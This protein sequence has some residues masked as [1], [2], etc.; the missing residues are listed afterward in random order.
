M[1]SQPRR[2]LGRQIVVQKYGG[3]SVA[4]TEKLRHVARRVA[5]T[6][7]LGLDIVV[8]VSA[9]GKTTDELLGLAHSLHR[10]PPRRELDVLVSSGERISMALLSMA[11]EEQ[12]WSAISLS[13]PQSGIRTDAN[14]FGARIQGVQPARVLRELA[15]GR[16]VVVAGYQ[17]ESPDGEITT[18]GRG[19]SDTSAVA[20]AAVLGAL[21]CEIYSDVPGVFTADPRIVDQAA[22]LERVSYEE[23]IA[24]SNLG[25]SVLDRRAVEHAARHRVEIHA[26]P[27]FGDGEGTVI[28]PAGEEEGMLPVIGVAGHRRLLR[29]RVDGDAPDDALASELQDAVG[30]PSLPDSEAPSGSH[31]ELLFP[32][33]EVAGASA[34]TAKLREEF[35]SRVAVDDQIGSVSVI[36]RGIGECAQ[37]RRRARLATARHRIV[38]DAEHV[39]DHAYT[40]LVERASVLSAIRSIHGEL[41]PAA[42]PAPGSA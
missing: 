37:R 15:G 25:A 30:V 27:T 6:R 1:S 36:G 19:G 20:L 5:A 14:H 42:S 10:E 26:R 8:V 4:D 17:G 23:M 39:I 22:L 12:G 32:T 18:L 2:L 41:I 13:G 3:S 28:A 34:V 38:V 11:I 33:D 35:G 7:E 31:R 9:M 24:F 16:V 29:V 40:L 21:R